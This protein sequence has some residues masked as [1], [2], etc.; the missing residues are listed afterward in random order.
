[1][2][3]GLKITKLRC[4]ISIGRPAV[5][6]RAVG[7]RQP[8]DLWLHTETDLVA[9]GWRRRRVPGTPE[10]GRPPAPRGYGGGGVRLR[11]AGLEAAGRHDIRPVPQLELEEAEGSL[12][13]EVGAVVQRLK[14][15]LDRVPA[16]QHEA[17][18]EQL[19]RQLRWPGLAVV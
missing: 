18:T 12:Q 5:A 8:D 16:D 2:Y 10:Y 19:V 11:M 17:G 14:R 3:I 13:H 9:P 15:R 6:G 7:W 4:R 1:M